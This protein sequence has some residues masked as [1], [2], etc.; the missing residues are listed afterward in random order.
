MSWRLIVVL[1]I[2]ILSACS[3]TKKSK[4]FTGNFSDRINLTYEDLNSINLTTYNFNIRK[5]TI[6]LNGKYGSQRILATI[7]YRQPCNYL[8]SLNSRLGI[9]V[10][11]IF[12]DSDT[13]LINDRIN[14]KL[15]YGSLGYI[16]AKYGISK[17][18][19]PLIFGD[20]IFDSNGIYDKCING[21]I[22]FIEFVENRRI[23]GEI[24][25][26]NYK[27]I[28]VLFGGESGGGQIQ[29]QYDN[30]M[31]RQGVIFPRNIKMNDNKGD[32]S[33]TIDYSDVD[34]DAVGDINFVPGNGY[35]SVLL[36]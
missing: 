21:R 11:R 27:I 33:L 8:I 24:N 5:A 9:E 34:F 30:F 4:S 17:N 15:F 3:V 6:E 10:A 23:S 7:R 29:I 12:L 22:G 13:V 14:R 20:Y 25:C 31:D 18:T 28:S 35:Q 19:I 1:L 26:S 2:F 16:E 36:Q 32:I